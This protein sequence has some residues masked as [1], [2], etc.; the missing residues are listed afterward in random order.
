M[1]NYRKIIR[2]F[3]EVGLSPENSTFK[4]K[5]DLLEIIRLSYANGAR[6]SRVFVRKLDFPHKSGYL[7]KTRLPYANRTRN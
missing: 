6:K 5:S 7:K 4:K 2:L 1:S 3:V